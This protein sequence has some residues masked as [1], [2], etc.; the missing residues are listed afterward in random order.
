MKNLK[1]Q[2]RDSSPRLF[3]L[4]RACNQVRISMLNVLGEAAQTPIRLN[5][6]YKNNCLSRL[7]VRKLQQMDRDSHERFFVKIGANDGI[8]GDPCGKLLLTSPQWR[9]LLVEPDP[10]CAAVLRQ[11]YSDDSRFQISQVAV[12]EFDGSR[13]FFTVCPS[14]IQQH[15]ELPEWYNQLGS[16]DRKHITN[17]LEGMLEPFIRETVVQTRRLSGLFKELGVEKIDFLHID[18]EGHDLK[19]LKTLDFEST[20]P[21]LILIERKHLNSADFGELLNILTGN[22][23]NVEYVADDVLASAPTRIQSSK[24]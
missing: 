24:R 2:F 15:P 13:T 12:D 7:L 5:Q 20:P 6:C 14:A 1:S 19:V 16:F 23:Y 22:N 10:D 9:G 17:H 3:Q 21:R 11:V 4:L 8:T 18:T